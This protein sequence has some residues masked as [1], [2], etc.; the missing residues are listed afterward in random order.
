MTSQWTPPPKTL[1]VSAGMLDAW[2]LLLLSEDAADCHQF[3]TPAGYLIKVPKPEHD[4]NG[5][6]TDLRD[7]IL[8]ARKTNRDWILIR[9]HPTPANYSLCH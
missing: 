8:E 9:T 4:Y 3:E 7:F 1:E 2:A 6:P 5:Q